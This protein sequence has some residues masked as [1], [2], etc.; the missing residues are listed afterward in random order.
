MKVKE[1][2]EFIKDLPDDLPV[3]VCNFNPEPDDTIDWHGDFE[4]AFWESEIV[5]MDKQVK[6]SDE[7]GEDNKGDVLAINF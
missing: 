6:Y 3:C 4:V 2:K 5:F 1:L 7:D